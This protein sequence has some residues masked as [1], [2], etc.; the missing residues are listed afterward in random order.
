M[1]VIAIGQLVGGINFAYKLQLA[2]N[3][4]HWKGLGVLNTLNGV[5][6]SFLH[7]NPQ[8]TLFNASN[9]FGR[10]QTPIFQTRICH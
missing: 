5:D 3:I 10:F 1:V 8:K 6:V 9:G 4:Y 2:Y 7:H